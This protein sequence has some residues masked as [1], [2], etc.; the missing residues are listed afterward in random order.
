MVEA[1]KLRGFGSKLVN[2]ER[3]ASR[4]CR[5]QFWVPNFGCALGFEDLGLCFKDLGLGSEDLGLGPEDWGL[6]RARVRGFGGSNFGYPILERARLPGF[7]AG[8]R[9]FVVNYEVLGR[10]RGTWVARARK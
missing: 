4:I 7:G 1:R 2:Y 3:Q 9:G 10:E 6:E 5:A 8:L